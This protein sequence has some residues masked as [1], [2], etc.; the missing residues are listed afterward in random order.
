MIIVPTHKRQKSPYRHSKTIYIFTYGRVI[1]SV[2]IHSRKK[3]LKGV[4]MTTAKWTINTGVQQ[5]LRY[6]V[7]R[8]SEKGCFAGVGWRCSMDATCISNVLKLPPRTLGF[9]WWL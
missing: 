8:F 7:A 3:I 1:V 6:H 2:Q 5:D 9:S 4:K